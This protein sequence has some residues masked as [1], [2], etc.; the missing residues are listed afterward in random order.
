MRK[1]IIAMI[2]CTGLFISSAIAQKEDDE[3]ENKSFFKKENL[4]VGGSV[5]AF[6]GQG[7]FSM[8]VGPFFGYSINRYIDVAASLNYNYISQRDQF[9]TFKVRQSI[10]GPGA[11]VRVFPVKF[12]FTQAQY[13]YN[14][15]KYKEI[16]GG[17]FPDVITKYPVQSFLVGGGIANG[18]EGVG[19]VFFSI[20][21]L[22]DVAGNVN[23]PYTDALNR[24]EP[25]FRTS[26]NIPL[27]QGKQGGGN[28]RNRDGRRR[29]NRRS[30]DY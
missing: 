2:L 26:I 16:Y 14:F 4:F 29:D 12:L 10:I 20:S 8:G 17:G 21:I 3:T 28:G 18:R 24:V 19:D 11:F 6:F 22:F 30:S 15:V 27:F 25:I 5:N 7:T 13:E 23:S 9:S 1:K